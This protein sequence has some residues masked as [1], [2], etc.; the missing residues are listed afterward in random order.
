MS[1]TPI[2]RGAVVR[3]HAD[4]PAISS[5]SPQLV[6]LRDGPV[7]M[8]YEGRVTED[9]ETVARYFAQAL[10]ADS[11][12]VGDPL[13]LADV[14]PGREG[15][16]DVA[17]LEDGGFVLAWG[18]RENVLQHFVRSFDADGT[19]RS[20]PV[21]VLT[22]MNA[23]TSGWLNVDALPAG[24]FAVTWT[25]QSGGGFNQATGTRIFTQSFSADATPVADAV[26]VS[27]PARMPPPGGGFG[28]SVG[29]PAGAVLEEGGRVVVWQYSGTREDPGARILG[30]MLDADG[31]PEG[32]IFRV[33][34]PDGVLRGRPEKGYQVLA[35][36]DG[37]FAVLWEQGVDFATTRPGGEPTV[38]A[39]SA[40]LLRR[41]DAEGEAR[42]AAQQLSQ[43][44]EP[45]ASEPSAVVLP[46]ATIAL[47]WDTARGG[48]P[49]RGDSASWFQRLDADFAPL[50]PPVRIE[51]GE[52]IG[53]RTAAGT[54][55]VGADPDGAVF[56]AW[57]FG[58]TQGFTVLT[59]SLHP[60]IIGGPEDDLLTAGRVAASLHGLEGNDTLQGGPGDDT[61]DGGPGNDLLIGGAGDDLLLG[62]PGRDTLE[63]GPGNDTLDGGPGNDVLRGGAGN[64]LLIGG[65]G[66]D[67]LIGGRG[68]DTLRGGPGD[69][70]LEGGPGRDLLDGGAGND[71]LLG[72]AGNDTLRG[73]AGNDT[74]DGGAGNDVLRGGAGRDLLRGGPGN[75]L[76]DGGAGR[77][78]LIG[79]AGDDT[80]IGGAGA[81][82]FV[83]A[84][85]HE[86]ATIRDF[87]PDEGDVL[88]LRAGLWVQD[89]T[90]QQVVNRF[91]SVSEAGHTVLEFRT[92]DTVVLRGFA[93][94][95]TL[96]EH[97]EIA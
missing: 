12:P 68:N 27:P 19:P 52:A 11:Q 37:G 49:A 40:V 62:G 17:A 15:R 91:A 10:G 24:G 50:A 53:D 55:T 63:G 29:I 58:G 25:G 77:D 81:D 28:D 13:E 79:G 33:T 92:G 44:G 1:M 66:N 7:L 86:R 87:S 75:D 34:E 82:T 78:T 97:I 51:P 9:G 88:Q 74:L 84:R 90:P 60:Q 93:D 14:V 41:F 48:T 95:D 39:G 36:P 18:P 85:G 22:P 16:F 96:V 59:Q 57:H 23:P 56:L 72:G 32:D 94:L 64:D 35:L 65:G 6:T 42:G 3:H 46:D 80:M 73:G 83:F 69:D 2:P 30:R 71:L 43:P 45:Y 54:L 26:P 61:L 38:I 5:L 70:T 47:V 89:L 67:L 8:V 31:Q 21:P 4:D 20:E 76:L